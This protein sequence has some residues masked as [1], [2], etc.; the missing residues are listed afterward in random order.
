MLKDV[1]MDVLE[2]MANYVRSESIGIFTRQVQPRS[3]LTKVN[4]LRLQRTELGSKK[5]FC[6][7]DKMKWLVIAHQGI[8]LDG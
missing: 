1:H 5:N 8:S 4:K 6:R 7:S 3:E 2:E